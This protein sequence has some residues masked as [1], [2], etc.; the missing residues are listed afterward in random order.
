MKVERDG[1]G[2]HQDAQPKFRLKTAQ[3]KKGWPVKA[4]K[5]VAKEITMTIRIILLLSMLPLPCL[6][7]VDPGTA[8]ILFQAG[9]AI[10]YA[11][12]GALAFFFRPIKNFFLGL[13]AK[14]TGSRGQTDTAISEDP[15]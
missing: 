4:A 5:S 2:H 10:F 14:V 13:K 15:G 1:E 7:Y 12:L 9:Y 8:G 6:A 11:I 3:S